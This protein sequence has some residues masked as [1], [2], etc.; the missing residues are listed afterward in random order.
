MKKIISLL[1]VLILFAT[2][3]F[4]Q[5][6]TFRDVSTAHFA[7]DAINW[8]S[9]PENGSFMVGDAGN[10]FHPGRHINKFE[11]AQI[12]AVAAGF[13][14]VA[15]GLP[16][17]EREIFARSFEIWLPFLDEMA[18][19]YSSWS[20]VVDRE[21]AFLLYRE[22]LTTDDV[23]GFVTRVG[24]SEQRPFLTRQQA[25][26]WIVRLVGEGE[27]AQEFALPPTVPFRDDA[28]ISH[29]YRRY[30][31]HA[32][33]LGIIQGA[34]GYVNPVAHFTRA[35]MA[36]VFHNVLAEE[37]PEI[38]DTGVTTA[39][40]GA[41]SSV[42]MDSH[43]GIE[44]DDA[45]EVFPVAQNAVITIDNVQRSVVFLREGMAAAALVDGQGRI[46][47]LSA[48]SVEE[49]EE[50]VIQG[51]VADFIVAEEPGDASTLTIENADGEIF[52]L[53]V[54]PEAQFSRNDEPLTGVAELRIG[55]TI[56][57]ETYNDTLQRA[58]ASG[59]ITTAHGRL[60][61]IRITERI[62][63]ITMQLEDSTASYFIRPEIFDAYELR[64]NMY[65][66]VKL[67]S[68]EVL[69]IHFE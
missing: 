33:D 36:V 45:A 59:E 37:A 4:A 27:A 2:P 49:P 52:E 25:V 50:Q 65:F 32:R 31:Y 64:I 57:A 53:E 38:I 62:A 51:V 13:R 40:S 14:H 46:V 48:R 23:R 9:D 26:A 69:D 47:S 21:I 68:R 6:Q 7:F 34:G 5:T 39:V 55:D 12:Y 67:N 1:F 10:N 11:A 3:V 18:E 43:V 56:T 66:H 54:T 19:E 8:V 16:E 17:N 44:S 20:R 29:A 60:T 58:A 22:I 41:I 35:E 63:E 28:Q 30:I 42:H 15:H 61:E 24:T